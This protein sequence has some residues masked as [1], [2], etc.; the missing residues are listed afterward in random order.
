MTSTTT[1]VTS[2]PGNGCISSPDLYSRWIS[3]SETLVINYSSGMLQEIS[4]EAIAGALP[5]KHNN[6]QQLT[7]HINIQP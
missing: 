2:K 3:P 4:S 5:I 6:P 7:P 1:S